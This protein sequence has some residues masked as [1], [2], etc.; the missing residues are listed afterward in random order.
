MLYYDMVNSLLLDM[1]IYVTLTQLLESSALIISIGA[2]TDVGGE[3]HDNDVCPQRAIIVAMVG[4]VQQY[5]VAMQGLWK[6]MNL[7]L[8]GMDI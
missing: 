4:I 1:T 5:A 8:L 7:N 3:G 2:A 6:K